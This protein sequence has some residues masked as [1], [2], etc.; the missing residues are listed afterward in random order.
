MN[1]PR[2]FRR[3]HAGCRFG[4]NLVLGLAVVVAALSGPPGG[5]G[6]AMAQASGPCALLTTDDI[7]PIASNASVSQG[8]STSF[9]AVGFSSCRYAWGA[10]MGSYKL[11]VTVNEA[12]RMFSGM[13]PEQ[14]KQGL[15]ASI[16][17]GTADAVIPDVGDAAVFKV[18]SPV[19]VHVTAYV[20]GRI[21][22]LHL[23]GLDA[24]GKKDQLIDRLKLAAS[25]L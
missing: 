23:D 17:A 24:R 7:E 5:D 4:F 3:Q 14:I 20:K 2:Q 11:D 13:S 1:S 16:T 6:I 25:R 8:V 22:Q 19:Y 21:V 18:D 9:E 15:Q 10:G 12:S